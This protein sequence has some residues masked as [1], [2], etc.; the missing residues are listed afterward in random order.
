MSFCD[1]VG[2]ASHSPSS[3]GPLG[4]AEPPERSRPRWFPPPN[5][6]PPHSRFE[7]RSGQL[8]SLIRVAMPCGPV[9]VVPRLKR[10][11]R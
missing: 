5:P 4:Y 11:P 8:H 2:T 6:A 7:R 1:I 3:S 9:V 10:A